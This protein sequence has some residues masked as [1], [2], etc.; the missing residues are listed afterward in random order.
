MSNSLRRLCAWKIT[1]YSPNTLKAL[2]EK[3]NYNNSTP[4]SK[5]YKDAILNYVGLFGTEKND[6]DHDDHDDSDVLL[7]IKRKN[8]TARRTKAATKSKTIIFWSI[9]LLDVIR[10]PNSFG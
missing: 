8:D 9:C 2:H 3:K 1:Y 7:N 5:Y 10:F 6:D 4:P